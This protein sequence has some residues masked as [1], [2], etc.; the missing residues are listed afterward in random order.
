M[1]NVICQTTRE[2][3]YCTRTFAPFASYQHLSSEAMGGNTITEQKQ[4]Q[5]LGQGPACPA[6]AKEREVAWGRLVKGLLPLVASRLQ[7]RDVGPARLVCRQWAAELPEGCTRLEVEGKGPDGWQHRFCGLEELKLEPGSSVD[8]QMSR[9][10]PGLVTL[11]LPWCKKIT[12]ESLKE[13]E[14]LSNLTILTL[15][16]GM[17]ITDAGLKEL[18]HIHVQPHLPRPGRMPKVDGRGAQGARPHAQAHPPQLGI[19]QRDGR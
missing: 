7:N 15:H 14:H 19:Q 18:G 9:D 17:N 11:S 13:L 5:L 1:S 8:L 4:A 3:S 2:P 16:G 6:A 10:L 12:D